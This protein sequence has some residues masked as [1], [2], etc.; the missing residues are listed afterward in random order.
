MLIEDNE[1]IEDEVTQVL[2]KEE[3]WV[4][5]LDLVVVS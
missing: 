2:H 1:D 3:P 5:H 4:N